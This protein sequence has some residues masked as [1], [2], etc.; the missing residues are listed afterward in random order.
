[1]LSKIIVLFLLSSLIVTK[2]EAKEEDQNAK[3]LKQMPQIF[4]TFHPLNYKIPKPFTEKCEE[5]ARVECM[6]ASNR[7]DCMETLPECQK[8]AQTR[9][10]GRMIIPTDV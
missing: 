5:A 8:P 3:I 4:Q 10:H 9:V 2:I 1:M 7:L 6:D